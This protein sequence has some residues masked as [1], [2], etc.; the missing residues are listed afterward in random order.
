MIVGDQSGAIHMWDL[1]TDHNEQ[2]V[3]Q[4]IFFNFKIPVVY[5]LVNLNL[6]LDHKGGLC[7]SSENSGN[8]KLLKRWPCVNFLVGMF[9]KEIH[10]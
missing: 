1:K 5:L 10:V 6:I 9:Q 4:G 7:I 3:S 8:N 2:L